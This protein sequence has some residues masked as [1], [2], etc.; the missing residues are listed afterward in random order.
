MSQSTT[1]AS[2]RNVMT[3]SLGLAAAT[4]ALPAIASAQTAAPASAG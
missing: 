4:A 2:R 3:A 1:Q